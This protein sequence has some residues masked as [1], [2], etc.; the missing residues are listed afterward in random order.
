M[1][2]YAPPHAVTASNLP[3]G[4]TSLLGNQDQFCRA[5]YHANQWEANV[6]LCLSY[7]PNA[8]GDAL[9]VPEV[10][11]DSPTR[12]EAESPGGRFGAGAADTRNRC[13]KAQVTII[14]RVLGKARE[15]LYTARY[16]NCFRGRSES[17]LHAEEFLLTDATLLTLLRGGA[18]G[19]LRLYMSYQPC[20]HSGGRLPEAKTAEEARRQLELAQQR[21][22]QG[23]P[24]SCS[25]RLRSFYE[26][27]LAEQGATLELVIADLYK[28]MW[29]ADLMEERAPEAV[30]ERSTYCADAAS[31]RQGMLLMMAAAGVTMRAM[32][33]HDW[34]YLVSLCDPAVR[35]AYERRGEPGSAFSR[36]HVMLRAKL[37]LV[38]ST[39]IESLAASAV[40]DL[41]KSAPVEE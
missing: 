35:E 15:E 9:V 20:H 36:T 6:C 34:A 7:Q 33:E 10:E 18:V 29:T 4:Y 5:F 31:A 41:T 27:E 22:N 24:T 21:Q 11:A 13:T 32:N 28:A 16:S 40:G 8:A 23:H 26:A 1:T 17:N 39:F 12:R 19:T 30:V 25:E 3:R 14:A 38:L 2:T 37:D